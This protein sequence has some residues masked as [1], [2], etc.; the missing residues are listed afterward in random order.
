MSDTTEGFNKQTE[1]TW[2][3]TGLCLRPGL[4]SSS[5]SCLWLKLETPRDLTSPASLQASKACKEEK[6]YILTETD[7]DDLYRFREIVRKKAQECE[8]TLLDCL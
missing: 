1:V 3:D 5:S 7:S 4:F 2:L 8:E 6:I